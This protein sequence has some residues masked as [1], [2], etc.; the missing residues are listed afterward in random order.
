MALDVHSAPR[1]ITHL[2]LVC[3]LLRGLTAP[4]LGVCPQGSVLTQ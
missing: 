1:T 2:G 3:V 4:F